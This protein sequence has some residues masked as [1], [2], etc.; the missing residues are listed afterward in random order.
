MQEAAVIEP[1]PPVLAT[2]VGN[3]HERHL[4]PRAQP[5]MPGGPG[6]VGVDPL[7]TE[8]TGEVSSGDTKPRCG[9]Y[10]RL[11]LVD[12]AV[13]L[14]STAHRTLQGDGRGAEGAHADPQRRAHELA[15]DHSGGQPAGLPPGAGRCPRDRD[16]H[17]DARPR[18]QLAPRRFR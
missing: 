18:A 17:G 12:P 15:G 16:H 6:S 9:T 8:G 14:A 2:L 13:T 3:A 11:A 1:A 10:G 5:V 4:P 7:L